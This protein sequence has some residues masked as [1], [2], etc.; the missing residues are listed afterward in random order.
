MPIIR[1]NRLL[2]AAAGF[3]IA[4]GSTLLTVEAQDR[5]FIPDM[6][7]AG[8][9]LG[10]RTSAKAFLEGYQPR[11]DGGQ[12][13]YYFYNSHVTT[14]MKLTAASFDDPYF[15]TEIEVFNVGPEY[16]NRHFVLEKVGHFVTESGIFVGFRQSGRGLAV[17]LIVGVPNI[18]RDN[19]TGPKDVVNKKGEPNE[20]VKNGAEDIFDY[21]LD[22]IGLPDGKTNYGY[23]AHYRFYDKKLNR[24]SMKI[25]PLNKPDIAKAK[26]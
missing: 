3:F 7:V 14:V 11:T 2:V 19:M 20:R 25:E 22:S 16:Q 5:P 15:V 1:S 26:R 10:D 6:S 13:T 24:F 18:A 4:F 9:K 8:V 23:S 21:R 12:P 17:A